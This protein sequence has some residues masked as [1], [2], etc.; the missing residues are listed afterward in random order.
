MLALLATSTDASME[1]RAAINALAA[2]LLTSVEEAT[3]LELPVGLIVQRAK[4]LVACD[5]IQ[6]IIGTT[7]VNVWADIY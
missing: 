2:G 4:Q 7:D 6:A 3:R 1:H 5:N